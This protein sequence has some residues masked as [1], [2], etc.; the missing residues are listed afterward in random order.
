MRRWT[1]EGAYPVVAAWSVALAVGLLVSSPAVAAVQKKERTVVHHPVVHHPVVR[2]EVVRHPV[3]HRPVI[4]H[5]VE[6]TE[7]RHA[8]PR[9]VKF[10]PNKHYIAHA[11]SPTKSGHY[12]SKAAHFKSL[13]YAST[14][15]SY[16]ISCVPYAREVTGMEIKGNAK[17]WWGNAAGIYARGR[18]PE[19]GS[20]L[21]FRGT[22]RMRLG[23]VA[24]VTKVVDARKV[25]VNHANWRGPGAVDGNIFI[26]IPV[27]DV[28]PHNDWSEVRVGLGHTGEY[29]G[30]VYPTNGFIYSRP[31]TGT[32]SASAAVPVRWQMAQTIHHEFR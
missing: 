31:D 7:V 8:A 29:G 32:M 10:E 30:T 20:V 13:R 14:R 1:K 12:V 23:H 5:V 27:I 21:S 11:L 2:R 28:S 16:G 4:H 15:R 18:M 22:A 24:V 25:I 19:P 3:V 6:R 9:R 17:D 26:G